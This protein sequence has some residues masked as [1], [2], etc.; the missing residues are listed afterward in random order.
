MNDSLWIRRLL[1]IYP[2]S[3]RRQHEEEML[4]MLQTEQ[5]GQ[6]LP[7]LAT[8]T[9]LVGRGIEIRT[10]N[11]L[12]PVPLLLRARTSAAAAVGLMLLSA[13]LLTVI[14]WHQPTTTSVALVGWMAAGL[15]I[16]LGRAGIGRLLSVPVTGYALITALI[17]HGDAAVGR[18]PLFVLLPMTLLGVLAGAETPRI[19][20]RDRLGLLRVVLLTACGMAVVAVSLVSLG[21]GEFFPLGYRGGA[22]WGFLHTVTIAVAA[23]VGGCLLLRRTPGWLLPLAVS[24]MV[25]LMIFD[26]AIDLLTRAS[27]ALIAMAIMLLVASGY[28]IAARMTP[29]AENSQALTRRAQSR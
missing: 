24:G 12:R 2:A 13:V 14:E 11:L 6:R 19:S 3:W 9:D 25:P 7:T 23:V 28:G 15:S 18:A 21:I 16:L 29:R 20:R 1:A 8:V 27:P 10:A 26:P 22:P 17:L 5:H 4:W